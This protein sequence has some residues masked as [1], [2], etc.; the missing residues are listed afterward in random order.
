MDKLAT[1][2][3]ISDPFSGIVIQFIVQ[4]RNI[5]IQYMYIVCIFLHRN[6]IQEKKKNHLLKFFCFC[7]RKYICF[8]VIQRSYIGILWTSQPSRPT[9]SRRQS[10][11]RRTARSLVYIPAPKPLNDHNPLTTQ[12]TELLPGPHKS[13]RI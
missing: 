6:K 1:F 12:V 2:V 4:F 8:G 7:L 9:P 5:N 10:P 11:A 13:R 3:C